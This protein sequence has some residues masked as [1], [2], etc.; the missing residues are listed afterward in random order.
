MTRSTKIRAGLAR[1]AHLIL[2][3]GRMQRMI[4]FTVFTATYNRAHTISRVFE[5]L[6][7]QT[8]R[9]F[10][11]VIVDDGSTDGTAELVRKWQS[12][13]DFPIR[14]FAQQNAGKHVAVNRG[15]REACGSFF[16][17][18][19]SD[20]ACVPEALERLRFHWTTIPAEEQER[21]VGVSALIQRVDGTLLGTPFPRE[22][23]DSNSLELRFKH[24]VIG[25]KWGFQRTEV[26]RR[27]PYP[28]F[29]GEKCVPDSLVWNRIAA[30]YQT[31][32]VN[33][34]LGIRH[35]TPGSWSSNIDAVRI[36]SPRA[37]SLYYS[38]LLNYGYAGA[39][40]ATKYH[41]NYVR[42]GLHAR[43]PIMTQARNISSLVFWI[44]TFPL[45]SMMYLKDRY[46]QRKLERNDTSQ[47]LSDKR[48]VKS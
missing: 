8:Y 45:G 37:A 7:R 38:E 2:A 27:F 34:P 16:V 30:E 31:R 18:I 26:M 33:E 36:G 20:N 12:Q 3:L 15:V 25:D 29:P 43:T 21:F 22:P 13:S 23:T 10:E 44:A 11:W 19:D 4:E 24:R 48:G 1:R 39:I 9:A 6:I 35:E 41:V 46:Q 42:F 14:Y 17:N 32:F 28:E 5:S 40:D 47:S